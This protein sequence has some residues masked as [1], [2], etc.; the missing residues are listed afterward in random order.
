MI[1]L[2]SIRQMNPKILE[3]NDSVFF[4]YGDTSFNTSASKI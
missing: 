2:S 1:L 3:K 4:R